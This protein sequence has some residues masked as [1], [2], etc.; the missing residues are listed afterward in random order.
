M[1]DLWSTGP[2]SS[3]S[4]LGGM[5][6]PPARFPQTGGD[7]SGNSDIIAELRG[8]CTLIT[9]TNCS[10]SIEL[11]SGG[12]SGGQMVHSSAGYA[13]NRDV[14]VILQQLRTRFVDVAIIADNYWDYNDVFLFVFF[15]F[16]AKC[17]N[18]A[19]RGVG[20][21]DFGHLTALDNADVREVLIIL[22]R[23]RDFSRVKLAKELN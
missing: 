18:T 2:I 15:Q 1:L 4:Q 23:T 17:L 10:F 9:V 3:S 13:T 12:L 19:V 5:V 11:V 6:G 16:F 8:R 7:L 14:E 20:D 22:F 21:I